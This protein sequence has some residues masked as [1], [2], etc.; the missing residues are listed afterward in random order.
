MRPSSEVMK[1]VEELKPS[2]PAVPEAPAACR[3][4]PEY[5]MPYAPRATILLPSFRAKPKRGPKEVAQPLVALRARD[6]DVVAQAEIER[7]VRGCAEVVL[8]IKA[9][10]GTGAAGR[11]GVAEEIE[12]QARVVRRRETSKRARR[13]SMR[14]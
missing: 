6:I 11:T 2:V 7:Q 4:D 1:F 10:A 14:A 3:A 8:N 13:G 5:M 12:W 9:R